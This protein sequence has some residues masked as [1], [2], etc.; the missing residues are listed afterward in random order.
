MTWPNTNKVKDAFSRLELLV[1]IDLFMTETAK[2]AHIFLPAATFTECQ[3]IREYYLRG[4]PLTVWGQQAIAPPGE[5]LPDWKIW[6]ELGRRMGYGEYFPWQDEDELSEYLL[7]RAGVTLKQSKQHQEVVLYHPVEGREYLK[8]GFNT[9]SGKVEIYS[10]TMAEHG[11]H[12]LPTFEEP[13]ESPVSRPDLAEKYPLIL[14]TGARVTAFS[15]SRYR[16][17]AALRRRCPEPFA[18]IN[19]KTATALGISDGDTVV[20]ESPRGGIELKAKVGE[21]I[22]PRVVSIQHGW[23]EANA[24]ILTDGG[25]DPI[26]G[27]PSLRATLCRVA[28]KQKTN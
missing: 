6:S 24:N 10:E 9:P 4:L 2:L 17:V 14:T 22:H 27:F 7:Q 3:S 20:V 25:R 5:S 1:A 12:P 16:N 28:K 11:Y 8:D 23:T 13:A 15:H 21:D 18:E 26:S 19:I